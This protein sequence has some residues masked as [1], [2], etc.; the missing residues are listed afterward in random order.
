ML[1]NTEQVNWFKESHARKHLNKNLRNEKMEILE[2]NL[3]QIPGLELK[4]KYLLYCWRRKPRLWL[5]D[6]RAQRARCPGC[7]SCLCGGSLVQHTWGDLFTMG[8]IIWRPTIISAC[9]PATK[10][11]TCRV[12]RTAIHLM[13][14]HHIKVLTSYCIITRILILIVNSNL[15][16]HG[17]LTL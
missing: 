5:W 6:G 17:H 16:S 14:S 2:W 13:P 1:I 7:Q 11:A 15:S 9:K 4:P 3:L 8:V 10:L 12:L